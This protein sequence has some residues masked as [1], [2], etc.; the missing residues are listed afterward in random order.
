MRVYLVAMLL[1][2]ASPAVAQ[3]VDVPAPVLRGLELLRADSVEAAVGVWSA[4]WTGPAD[5]GKAPQLTASLTQI[6]GA[7]GRM[8]AYD[9]LTVESVGPH[10]RRVSAL[11]RYENLPIFA[12]FVVYDRGIN[13]TDW[14][15]AKVT[16]NSEPEK[17][18]PPTVWPH[19]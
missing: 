2:I 16:W 14:M 15:V 4:A 17:V 7:A 19:E 5:A 10:L 3:K 8:R 18:L 12:E 6:A 9:I 11:L 13:V 1:G